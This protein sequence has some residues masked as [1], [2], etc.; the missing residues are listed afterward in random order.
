MTDDD[1]RRGMIL[2]VSDRGA[3]KSA[4]TA[5]PRVTG[6]LQSVV[7]TS[8]V[9][10]G[11]RFPC[12]PTGNW[13]FRARLRLKSAS[14]STGPSQ[15]SFRR[16]TFPTCLPPHSRRM[17]NDSRQQGERVDT[18]D[19]TAFSTT[20]YI[21]GTSRTALSSHGCKGMWTRSTPWRFPHSPRHLSA[22]HSRFL[23]TLPASLLVPAR[24]ISGAER[25]SKT[26]R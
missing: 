3:R 25:R 23:A 14:R 8:W 16:G 13:R 26:G 15:T 10:A 4:V 20:T 5:A 9:W 12:P 1:A 17:A 2:N 6:E 19:T 18:R 21:S 7:L 24:S 22:G 11:G